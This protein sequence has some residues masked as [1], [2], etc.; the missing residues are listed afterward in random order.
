MAIIG[1]P[2]PSIARLANMMASCSCVE[3]DLLHIFTSISIHSFRD[4]EAVSCLRSLPPQMATACAARSRCAVAIGTGEAYIRL[5]PWLRQDAEYIEPFLNLFASLTS[6]PKV[7]SNF[8]AHG[9]L[10]HVRRAFV[11]SQPVGREATCV[12]FPQKNEYDE[13]ECER[14]NEREGDGMR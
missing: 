11:S 12:S 10:L 4:R 14:E 9:A 8:L 13:N 3:P 7:V 6:Q 5:F 2:A 1:T